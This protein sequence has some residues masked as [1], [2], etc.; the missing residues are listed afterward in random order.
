MDGLKWMTRFFFSSRRRHTRCLSDWI[1]TCDLPI[2]DFCQAH[3]ADEPW[4]RERT[5]LV[6]DPYFSATKFRWLLEQ[7]PARRAAA[8]RGELAGGTVDSFV[9]SE[10]RRGGKECRRRGSRAHEEGGRL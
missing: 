6:L 7:D 1:Q 10:E 9:R 3:R 5:G 2:S 4:L 8:E